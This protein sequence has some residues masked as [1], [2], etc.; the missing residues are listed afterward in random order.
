MTTFFYSD[1]QD[2][3]EYTTAAEIFTFLVERS[4]SLD[5][6]R[7]A[8]Y[9]TVQTPLA[10]GDLRSARE[11]YELIMEVYALAHHAAGKTPLR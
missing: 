1:E 2:G 7:E 3:I 10:W 4:L 8:M 11:I 9:K 5:D 6:W